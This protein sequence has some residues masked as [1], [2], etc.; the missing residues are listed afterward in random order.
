MT[1]LLTLPIAIPLVF[2]V[3]AILLRGSKPAQIR[4]ALTGAAGLL[5][6][7][8]LLTVTVN[9]HGIQATQFGNWPAPFGISFVADHLSSAMVLISALLGLACLVYSIGEIDQ[10][11]VSFGFF[12]L[13]LVLQGSVNGAFLT[14]DLFNLYVWFEVLLITSFVLL[15][16]GNER[17]QTK[18]ALPYI[19]LHL[20][21]SAIFLAAVGTIYGMTGSLNMAELARR[22]GTPELASALTPG[23][24][25]LFCALGTKAAVFPLFFWLPEAYPTP[26]VSV[27]AIFAGLLTKVGIYALLRIFTLI[28]VHDT[29]YAHGI[30]LAL[31]GITMITGVLGA[32]AQNEFRRILSFHIISQIGYMIMGLALFSP[33]ALSGTLFFVIHN[34]IVKSNLFLIS[35]VTYRL[36][37]SFELNSLGGLY[38]SHPALSVLFLISAFSLAGLPPLS[39][40]WGKLLLA[41]AG[42]DSG[43]YLII[44]VS[45][46]VSLLTLF[47]MLKIWI[48][49]FWKP[50]TS[51]L[52]SALRH[53]HQPLYLYL[54]PITGLAILTMGLGLFPSSLIA[55]ANRAGAELHNPAAYIQAVLPQGGIQ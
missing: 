6:V 33:L 54:L 24:I 51:H 1:L 29:A 4:L 40:F 14:G 47:S 53:T 27:S 10:Q 11:R 7:A 9:R 16:L 36:R 19:T 25:L 48:Q 41:K 12:P 30:L 50:I 3:L 34:I 22:A 52:G 35:G 43:Q 23:A 18:G 45:L 46:V 55:F 32:A 8:I 21:S 42:F 38:R 28:F 39:G 49:A 44:S 5:V 2:A 13:I 31:S 17:T 15:T 37:G 20:F 26:P